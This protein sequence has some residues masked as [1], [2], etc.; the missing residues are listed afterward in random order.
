MAISKD[1]LEFIKEQ[2]GRDPRGVVEIVVVSRNKKPLVI[3]TNP[4]IDDEVFPTLYYLVNKPL[5]EKV[6][7][8]ESQ[9]YLTKMQEKVDNDNDFKEELL[10]AQNKYIDERNSLVENKKFSENQKTALGT[11]IGGVK[12]LSRIKCLHSHL[13]YYLATGDGPVGEQVYNKVLPVIKRLFY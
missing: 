8:L 3:K 12:D 10:T 7:R 11:G 1:D 5:I 2:L 9:G 6:S 13:A 4:V